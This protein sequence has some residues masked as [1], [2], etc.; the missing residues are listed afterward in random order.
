MEN[1]D[2]STFDPHLGVKFQTYFE[3]LSP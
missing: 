1:E 3:E 2:K